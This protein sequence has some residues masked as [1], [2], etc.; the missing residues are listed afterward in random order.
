MY[1]EWLGS[2]REDKGASHM[3]GK[4]GGTQSLGSMR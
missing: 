1:Y 4:E 3:K 2:P